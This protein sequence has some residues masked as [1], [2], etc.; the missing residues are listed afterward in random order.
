MVC[1][2][3]KENNTATETNPCMAGTVIAHV[4][5]FHNTVT[6]SEGIKKF[7]STDAANAMSHP[8]VY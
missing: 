4:C 6:D 3:K 8:T 2:C 7:H 1:Y 5:L